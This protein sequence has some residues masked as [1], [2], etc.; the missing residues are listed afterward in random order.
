VKEWYRCEQFQPGQKDIRNEPVVHQKKIF[1][2][3]RDKEFFKVLDYDGKTSQY[4]LQNSPQISESKN[5]R[6]KLCWSLD[7]KDKNFDALLEWTEGGVSEALK[8]VA[9]NFLGKHKSPNYRTLVENM[10]KTF[11]YKGWNMSLKLHF[12]RSHLGV[13]TSKFGYVI[14]EHDERFH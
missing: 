3:T 2:L 12:H 14:D 4:L 1:V 7:V 6:G 8:V 11:S 10:L 13:F 5:Q 9:Y